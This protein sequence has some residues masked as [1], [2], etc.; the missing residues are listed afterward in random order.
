MW[1]DTFLYFQWLVIKT[2]FSYY[3]KIVEKN[4]NKINKDLADSDSL[5]CEGSTR[6]IPATEHY[7]VQFLHIP[8]SQSSLQ[9]YPLTQTIRM[10]DHNLINFTAQL[11]LIVW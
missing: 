5:T 1:L 6:S 10:P 8:Y 7:P 11:K 2:E 4:I 9:C 3:N